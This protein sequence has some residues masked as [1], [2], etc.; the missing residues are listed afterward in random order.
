MVADVTWNSKYNMF[1]LSGFGHQFPVMVYVYQRSEE[2][3]NEILYSAAASGD[4]SGLKTQLSLASLDK[5]S[6]AGTARG[7]KSDIFDKENEHIGT[8]N[9]SA[10]PIT[11]LG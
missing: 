3:L 5:G 2:Q 7:F 6:N 10:T 11:F 4:I 1:A 8:V 9:V